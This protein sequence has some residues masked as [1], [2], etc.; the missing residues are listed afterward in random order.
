MVYNTFPLPPGG[1]DALDALESHGKDV[2]AARAEH[3]DQ[4]LANLY[5]PLLMPASLR[6]AHRRLDRAVDRLYRH[7]GFR[8]ESDRAAHL[9]GLYEA[10]ADPLNTPKERWR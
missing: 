4:S 1:K 7:G 8:S 5:D 9:L 10:S 2:L 6:R 3:R